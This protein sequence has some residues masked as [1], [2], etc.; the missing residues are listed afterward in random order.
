MNDKARH[1]HM[2]GVLHVTLY[3]LAK[4]AVDVRRC[5]SLWPNLFHHWNAWMPYLPFFARQQWAFALSRVLK[6]P[7]S[8]SG[9]RVK[10]MMM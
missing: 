4:L 1:T 3:F 6:I 7:T 2:L 8:N 5:P 9:A 10:V